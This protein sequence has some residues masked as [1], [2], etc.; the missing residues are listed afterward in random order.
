M[1]GHLRYR[2]VVQ[3]VSVD[4]IGPETELNPPQPFPRDAAAAESIEPIAQATQDS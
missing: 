1:R 3:K 2:L 4:V